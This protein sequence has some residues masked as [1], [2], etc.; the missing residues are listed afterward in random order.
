ML[1]IIDRSSMP[2]Q[3]E[4]NDMYNCK[5]LTEI[6]VGHIQ[7]AGLSPI[8]FCYF[9]SAIY[10]KKQYTCVGYGNKD[11]KCKNGEMICG[12]LGRKII[13]YGDAKTQVDAVLVALE[14]E[15]GVHIQCPTRL[16]Q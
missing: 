10:Y 9:R 15:A 3:L 16:L 1:S 8:D 14:S 4:E 13:T 6:H 11:E 12:G 7:E 2:L 5:A